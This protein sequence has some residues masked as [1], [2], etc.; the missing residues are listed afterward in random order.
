MRIREL[1]SELNGSS[2]R[3]TRLSPTQLGL[4]V[5]V[6]IQQFEEWVVDIGDEI[7]GRADYATGVC[8]G[9]S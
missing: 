2:E 8:C 1:E 3:G 7:D 4:D 6:L 9:K 5:G